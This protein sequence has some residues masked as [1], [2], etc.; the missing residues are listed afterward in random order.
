MKVYLY[1]IDRRTDEFQM[2]E[3]QLIGHMYDGLFIPEGERYARYS[4]SN[5]PGEVKGGNVWFFER[6]DKAAVKALK[7]HFEKRLEVTRKAIGRLE[8]KIEILGRMI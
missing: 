2:F 1:R 5:T 4:V 6:S 8:K 7:A 3:G